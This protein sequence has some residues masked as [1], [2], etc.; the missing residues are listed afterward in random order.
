MFMVKNRVATMSFTEEPL[1]MDYLESIARNMRHELH[2]SLSAI[3]SG[4]GGVKEYMPLLVD[5]Y[6]MAVQ[7][8]LNVPEIQTNH[9]MMLARALELTERAA[10]CASSY[11]NI[12]ATNL[13]KI[14]PEKLILEEC[15]IQYCLHE[16]VRQFPCK[17]EEQYSLLIDSIDTSGDFILLGNKALIINLLLN[18]FKNAIYHI[19]DAGKGEMKIWVQTGTDK[20]CLFIR[21]TGKGIDKVDLASIFE[22]FYGTQKQDVGMGLFFCKQLML[23]LKGDIKC[24][25]KKDSFTEFVIEFPTIATK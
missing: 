1:Q 24:S 3:K 17:S 15:S 25:S 9:L 8:G 22:P 5:A 14:D 13:K 12:L 16:A 2:T 6:K 10:F 7:Q 4:I 23:A 19:Q 21:D 20:N 11:V 18:L